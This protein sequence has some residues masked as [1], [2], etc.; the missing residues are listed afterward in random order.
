ML[1]K[2]QVPFSLSNLRYLDATDN[3]IGE[4]ALQVARA[5]DAPN[6]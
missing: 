4:V 6:A 2:T 3:S 1:D 5:L